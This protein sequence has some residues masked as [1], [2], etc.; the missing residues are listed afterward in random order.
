MAQR[1][2]PRPSLVS[3]CLA[4]LDR[5]AMFCDKVSKTLRGAAK[6]GRDAQAACRDLREAQSLA[7]HLLGSVI[8]FF[9]RGGSA[10]TC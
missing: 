5:M 7:V 1:K 9:S 6:M 3:S 4:L 10:Q 8:A 2:D